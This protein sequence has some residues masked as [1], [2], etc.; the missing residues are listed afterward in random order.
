MGDVQTG[1]SGALENA[2]DA[3]LDIPHSPKRF[4]GFADGQLNADM[5]KIHIFG[6]HVGDYMDALSE[7]D[8]E[9][10]KKHFSKYIA[11]GV[12]SENIEEMY[13]KAHASIRA[14][15]TQVAK[16]EK[17]VDRSRWNRARI[18]AAQRN[19]RVAQ[20]KASFLRAQQAEE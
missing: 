16:V 19:N 5:H 20:V 7:E 11:A 13:T 9:K 2:E 18:S 12:D 14:D 10:Y 6:G 4:P 8:E 17:S 1:I 15:P 3:G